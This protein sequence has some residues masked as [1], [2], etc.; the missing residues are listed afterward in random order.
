MPGRFRPEP[1]KLDAMVIG[2]PNWTVNQIFVRRQNRDETSVS[3][4]PPQSR[5]CRVYTPFIAMLKLPF[6]SARS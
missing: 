1:G 6:K 3:P 5:G 4:I 2:L